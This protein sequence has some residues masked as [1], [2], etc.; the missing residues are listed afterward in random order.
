MKSGMDMY[1]YIYIYIYTYIHFL[2]LISWLSWA[3]SQKKNPTLIERLDLQA[4]YG[5]DQ[6]SHGLNRIVGAGP[7]S[8]DLRINPCWGTRPPGPLYRPHPKKTIV[9]AIQ[10]D[11]KPMSPIKEAM[12]SM[13]SQCYNPVLKSHSKPHFESHGNFGFNIWKQHKTTQLSI[14]FFLVEP[15]S[16]RTSTRCGVCEV[17]MLGPLRRCWSAPWSR[18]MVFWMVSKWLEQL[19]TIQKNR[20]G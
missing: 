10:P 14:D 13:K 18:R 9:T 12:F 8:K 1:I 3:F 4:I 16:W 7:S 5:V 2:K 6:R 15:R 20:S 19:A 11:L 17:K